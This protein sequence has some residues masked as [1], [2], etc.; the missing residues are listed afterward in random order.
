MSRIDSS[1][2]DPAVNGIPANEDFLAKFFEVFRSR[3]D[4]PDLPRMDNRFAVEQIE[5]RSVVQ[6]LA[7]LIAE[8]PYFEDA[9]FIKLLE[10]APSSQR[11]P[12]FNAQEY[13]RADWEKSVEDTIALVL[14]RRLESEPANKE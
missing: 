14:K 11:R 9:S 2:W 13:R 3:R 10:C 4:A 7:A 6:M 5:F 12:V 1:K 8:K